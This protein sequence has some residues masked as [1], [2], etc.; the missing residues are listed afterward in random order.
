MNP[1]GSRL[2]RESERGASDSEAASDRSATRAPLADAMG[3]D[4][5]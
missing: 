3:S 1:G 4:P 5:P 2:G